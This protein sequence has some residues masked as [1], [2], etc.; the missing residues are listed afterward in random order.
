LPRICGPDIDAPLTKV[1]D[2]IT[3]DFGR[4]DVWDK[5]TACENLHVPPMAI[6]AWDINDL[7]LPNTSWINS[8]SAG[9]ATPLVSGEVENPS[10]CTNTVWAG[11]KLPPRR[12]RQLRHVR[13]GAEAV[14]RLPRER[15]LVVA[16]AGQHVQRGRDA[17][18]HRPL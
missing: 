18:P 13:V 4:A 11:G 9:C 5:R 12:H 8:S 6:M 15:Q 1:L 7:F 17:Q 10:G 16:A 14:Q 2:Q 3:K